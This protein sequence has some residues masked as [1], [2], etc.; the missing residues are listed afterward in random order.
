MKLSDLDLPKPPSQPTSR[1]NLIRELARKWDSVRHSNGFDDLIRLFKHKYRINATYK[2][3]GMAFHSIL[4]YTPV[5]VILD[6][7]KEVENV[8]R[9]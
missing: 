7:I 6:L 5:E 1:F 2:M 3:E 4:H 8:K 9:F